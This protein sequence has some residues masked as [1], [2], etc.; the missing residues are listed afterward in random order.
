MFLD[1]MNMF[2]AFHVC[3]MFLLFLFLSICSFLVSDQLL[4]AVKIEKREKKKKKKSLDAYMKSSTNV[5]YMN[6][7]FQIFNS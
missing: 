3:F 2:C 5:E 6:H 4:Q 7:F 1:D